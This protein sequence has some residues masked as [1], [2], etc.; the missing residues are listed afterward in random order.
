M[1]Q[2]GWVKF[3]WYKKEKMKRRYRRY[4]WK[5]KEEGNYWIELSNLTYL[6]NDVVYQGMTTRRKTNFDCLGFLKVFFW[7]GIN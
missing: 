4:V 7:G 5:E 3:E 1:K 6:L 2:D